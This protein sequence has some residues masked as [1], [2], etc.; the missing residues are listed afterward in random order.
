MHS[1]SLDFNY[2]VETNI[3]S[4]PIAKMEVICV[5]EGMTCEKEKDQRGPQRFLVI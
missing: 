4:D 2:K 1:F 3:E 5:Y